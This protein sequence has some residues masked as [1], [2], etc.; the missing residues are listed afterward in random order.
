MCGKLFH[1]RI[2][3]LSFHVSIWV[4][5]R[6]HFRL[7]LALIVFI[8]DYLCPV[9]CGVRDRTKEWH[10]SLSSL[11]VVK[12]DYRIYSIHTWDELRS[13]GDGLTACHVCSICLSCHFNKVWAGRVSEIYLRCLCYL[14]GDKAWVICIY[15]SLHNVTLVINGQIS[16]LCNCIKMHISKSRS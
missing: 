5:S 6:A 2:I 4:N 15:L 11:D 16:V 13:G 7:R 9:P 8:W 10:V 1:T 3:I 12:G 14:S